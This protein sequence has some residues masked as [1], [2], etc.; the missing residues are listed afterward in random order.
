[1]PARAP[2][3]PPG[4]AGRVWLARRLEIA[5]RGCDVL[6][7]KRRALLRERQRL[8]PLVDAAEADWQQQAAE[9][10]EWLARATVLSGSRRLRL[11]RQYAGAPATITVPW[12]NTLGVVVPAPPTLEL[13]PPAE[14]T[15]VGGSA[16]LVVS[17]ARHRAALEAAARLAALRYAHHAVS[18]ELERTTRR[19]RAIERRW[20]PLHADAL[21]ALT[22]ALD[23]V[24]R[25]DTARARWASEHVAL[26]SSSMER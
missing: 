4:R 23:E 6:E 26:P 8:Q 1:M 19:L 18:R 16:A 7:E 17:Q 9:A 3:M 12:Q 13:P 22:L 2:R 25:E 24:E 5:R 10:A 20:I 15:H 14:V 21:A 11:A